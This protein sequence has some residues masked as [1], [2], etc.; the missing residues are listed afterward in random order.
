MGNSKAVD[1]QLLA[2]VKNEV[3]NQF[4]CVELR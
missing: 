3:K 1:K 2:V 4:S